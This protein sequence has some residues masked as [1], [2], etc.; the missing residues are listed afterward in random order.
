MA[1]TG[2][3]HGVVVVDIDDTRAVAGVVAV[4][5][6]AAAAAAAMIGIAIADYKKN[7][8]L[9]ADWQFYRGAAAAV[10]VVGVVASQDWQQVAVDTAVV[11]VVVV[12][13]VVAAAA[14][15]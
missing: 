11:V 9:V 5:E 15:R 1:R 10:V 2:N 13:V 4:G 6:V 8:L 14:E 7:G 3:V 12:V